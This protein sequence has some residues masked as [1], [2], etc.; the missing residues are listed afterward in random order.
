MK[1]RV[2]IALMMCMGICTAGYQE[3]LDAGEFVEVTSTQPFETKPLKEIVGFEHSFVDRISIEPIAGE[4]PSSFIVS[5]RIACGSTGVPL[6]RIPVL[7]GLDGVEP[8]LAG[9][10]NMDGEFKFRLWVRE[11]LRRTE[12]QVPKDFSGFLYVG[13]QSGVIAYTGGHSLHDIS[14][15]KSLYNSQSSYRQYSLKQ[16]LELS[17]LQKK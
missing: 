10:T 12:I 4:G 7:I 11:E 17:K 1:L 9:L 15:S 16:L 6:E 3:L 14:K 2:T 13:E 5:G 8:R